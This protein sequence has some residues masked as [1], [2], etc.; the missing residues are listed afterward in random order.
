MEN[1]NLIAAPYGRLFSITNH[2][3]KVLKCIIIKIIHYVIYGR[4]EP[5]NSSSFNLSI[6]LSHT[7]VL[8]FKEYAY[9]KRSTNTLIN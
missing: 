4:Q 8:H 7:E 9:I 2:D 6:D 1:F 5:K 3:T